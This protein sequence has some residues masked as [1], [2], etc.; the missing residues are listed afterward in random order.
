MKISAPRDIQHVL[1]V[2]ADMEWKL[3]SSVKA[4]EVFRVIK[5]IGKGGFGSIYLMEHIPSGV[6]LAGKV[7]SKEVMSE[8]AQKSFMKEIDLLKKIRTPFTVQYYGS[9]VFNGRPVILMEYC[10][11]GSIRDLID[12]RDLCLTE[13]QAAIVIHDLLAA[14]VMLK[15]KYKLMHRDIKSANILLKSNGEIKITDFGISSELNAENKFA[16]FST[17][18]T[19]YWMAPEVI[20]GEAQSYPADIWSV[21]ATCVELIEGAPPYCEFDSMK[22]MQK[23]S[24]DGFP[25]F[26]IPKIMTKEFKDF[27]SKCVAKDPNNR[28]NAVQLMKHPWIQQVD[29]LDRA[30]V[31][32]SLT[33]TEID[34]HKLLQMVGENTQNTLVST[35]RTTL[36]N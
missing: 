33:E 19:P 9:I 7:I 13:K 21:G 14:L 22:A 17:K 26:R 15:G 1:H 36:R 18:G 27:V 11:R 10:D 4:E 32:K 2:G 6:Q 35:A 28:W 34:L 5:E 23:I 31:M 30:E 8:A 25:G 20:R 3:D 24:T 29:S 12:Y 16:T